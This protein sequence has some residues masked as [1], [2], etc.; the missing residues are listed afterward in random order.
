MAQQKSSSS[1]IASA[2]TVAGLGI[3]W[4]TVAGN[5]PSQEELYSA[6]P[7][8]DARQVDTSVAIAVSATHAGSHHPYLS[9]TAFRGS[10]GESWR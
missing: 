8:A 1:V 10:H 2:I 9:S 6:A 3:V 7:P 4:V 5:F